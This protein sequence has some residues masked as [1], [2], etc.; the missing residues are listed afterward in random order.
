MPEF[1]PEELANK[2]SAAK[3]ICDWIINITMY[4]DVVVSVEPKKKAVA[5]AEVQLAEAMATKKEYEDLVAELT[6][7]L[8][9]LQAAFDKANA[10]K[11]EAE[12]TAA[13]CVRR[14]DLAQRLVSALGAEGERWSQS[15]ITVG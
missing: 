4:Y 12:A 13:R 15:I 2:S 10:D 9:V 11:E 8:A 1:T 14:L 6:A 7:K 3:G 5:E